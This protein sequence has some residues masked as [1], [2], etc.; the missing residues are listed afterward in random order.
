MIEAV[1]CES[2]REYEILKAS[3]R[4]TGLN[5]LSPAQ[6]DSGVTILCLDGYPSSYFPGSKKKAEAWEWTHLNRTAKI[7][8][9]RE[10]LV[11]ELNEDLILLLK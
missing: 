2:Y 3:P 8:T 1:Y 5:D 9:V 10:F 4:W 7:G 11:E 6:F